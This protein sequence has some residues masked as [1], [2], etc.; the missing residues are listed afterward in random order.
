MPTG[1]RD[2]NRADRIARAAIDVVSERG[3]EG[4]THRAVA[5]AAQVPLGST[6]YHFATRDD[7]LHAALN[8]ALTSWQMDLD[9]WADGL[10][11]SDDLAAALCE[12]HIRATGH[13]RARAVV[14]YEL[15]VA[16]L[17]RPELRGLANEWDRALEALLTDLAG[18]PV[19]GRLL[20]L[21]ASGLTLQSL[22]RGAPLEIDEVLPLFRSVLESRQST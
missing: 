3:V 18:D 17:R 16:A 8:R 6:T 10:G 13:L 12:W 22:T 20:A 14:E 1:E 9:R 2:P 21:V 5:A 7:L 19:T 4:L 11:D 15:Y